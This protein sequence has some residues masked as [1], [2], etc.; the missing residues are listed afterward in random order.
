MRSNAKEPVSGG[1]MLKAK[2]ARLVRVSRLY[3]LFF[4]EEDP[5]QGLRRTKALKLWLDHRQGALN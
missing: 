5:E 1:L 4:W 3:V 2:G